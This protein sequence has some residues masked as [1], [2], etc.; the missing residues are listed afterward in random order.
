MY[1]LQ[2]N[3]IEL[4]AIETD[5]EFKNSLPMDEMNEE[6]YKAFISCTL[7][8]K[9]MDSSNELFQQLEGKQLGMA[10]VF[11][12]RVKYCH[13]Y[14]ISPSLALFMSFIIQ[15]FG[16]S[17]IYANYLQY[18]A[19][20][21]NQKHLDMEFL[22]TK[23]F[24]TG[25]PSRETLKKVWDDQKIKPKKSCGSDNLL[26]YQSCQKSISFNKDK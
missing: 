19:H 10:S 12:L 6:Q 1:Q 24:L 23:C 16:D 3:S 22:F 8:Q 2:P 18:K 5:K 15:N 13:T 7:N 26:D 20:E 21:Y 17:T 4:W 25:F 11:W 9:S 14:T